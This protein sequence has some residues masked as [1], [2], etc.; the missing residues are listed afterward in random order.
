MEE[1]FEKVDGVISVTSGLCSAQTQH[2]HKLISL[3][4]IGAD[5]RSSASSLNMNLSEF[6]QKISTSSKPVVIDFWAPWC[7]PCKITKPI[8]ESLADEFTDK[9]E[10]LPINADNSRD[11]LEHFKVIGIP[12]VLTFRSGEMVGRVTGAQKEPAYRAMFDAL[13]EGKEVK[14]PMSTLDRVLRLGAGGLLVAYGVS[15]GNWLIIGIGAVV[16]FLGVYDRCPIW[17]A[18]TGMIKAKIKN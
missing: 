14:I 12:T 7:M 3:N 2:F 15:T 11:L 18:V 9:V 16:A 17:R 4:I 1:A 5:E 6:Q 13:A 8:L 10:F